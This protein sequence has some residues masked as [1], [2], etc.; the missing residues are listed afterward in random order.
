[1]RQFDLE[2]APMTLGELR[3]TVT[4]HTTDYPDSAEVSAFFA[5]GR[6]WLSMRVV[7][8]TDILS[9]V[10][11]DCPFCI[12]EPTCGDVEDC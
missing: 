9:R 4:V 5:E 11:R 2:L 7:A 8:D 6:I 1:M 12:E 10:Y 3:R